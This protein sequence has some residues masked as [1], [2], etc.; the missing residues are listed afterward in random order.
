MTTK[1]KQNNKR[2]KALVNKVAAMKLVKQKP[3]Q[4]KQTPFSDVGRIVGNSAGRMLGMPQLSGIGKWLGSGIGS[5]FGSGDYAM[6]GPTPQYNILS[7]QV[8]QFSK[9]HATNIV[10]HREYLGDINGTTAFTNTTYPLN[11]GV[12]QTFPWL[13]TIAASYQQYK[14]HGLIFEFRPL[15]TDFVTGGAPGVISCKY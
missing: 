6:T 9:T 14:F 11:P 15:I 10:S 13:S 2:V 4:S 5:I 1:S 7:G 3:K 12:S 8:P